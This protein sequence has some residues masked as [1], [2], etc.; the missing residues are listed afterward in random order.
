M[1]T[2]RI[3]QIQEETAYPESV[4][5]QQAL[6]KVWNETEQEQLSIGAVRYQLAISALEAIVDPIG[7]MRKQ[8]KEDE[9]LDGMYAIR[10]AERPEFYQD[11]AK[12]ALEEIANCT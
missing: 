8:L 10:I 4:S 1:N 5:V 12:K 7:H 6:L 11:I 3:K 9:R 2:E